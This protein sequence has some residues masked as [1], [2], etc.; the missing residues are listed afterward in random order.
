MGLL[1]WGELPSA[2]EFNDNAMEASS[3]ELMEFR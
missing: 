1:V 3:R 2:Y